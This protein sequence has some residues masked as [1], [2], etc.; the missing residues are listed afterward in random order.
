LFSHDKSGIIRPMATDSPQPVPGNPD[1]TPWAPWVAGCVGTLLA[2]GGLALCGWLGAGRWLFAGLF[3][4]ACA[5]LWLGVAK[6]PAALPRGRALVAILAVG[7]AL[8]GLFVW[9]W[10]AD[11]DL[12]RSVV[13]GALQTAGGNPYLLAPADPRTAALLPVGLGP[14]LANVNHKDLTAVYPPLSE[15]AFRLVAT[16]SPTRHAFKLAAATT[17][18]GACLALA[19]LVIRLGLPVQALALYAANPLVVT[20]T[21]G[22][23]HCDALAALFL[24]LAMLLFTGRRDRTGFVC[25]GAAGMAK[26]LAFGLAPFLCRPGRN[27]IALFTLLPLVLFAPFAG[28]GGHVFDSL[29]TMTAHMAFGA[30]LGVVLRPVCG[31]ATPLVA[32]GLVL[33]A[34]AGIWLTVQDPWRGALAAG[35]VILAGLPVLYPWY[36]LLIIPLLVV[37]PQPAWLWL[38]AGQGLVASPT[39]LRSTDLGGEPF[40]ILLVWLVFGLLLVWGWRRPSGLL[41]ARRFEPVQTLSV[42][43]PTRDEADRLGRLLASLAPA[44]KRGEI[45]DVVVADGGSRDATV[46]V[47]LAHGATVVTTGPSRGGQIAAGVVR[48]RGEA[49]LVLHADAVCAPDVPARVLA[50]LARYP[51]VTGGAVGMRF[52]AGGRRLGLVARLNAWR[53]AMTG[54]SFGDQGQFFRRKALDAVGGFPAMALMEDVELGLRLREA[55]ETVLLGGGLIVSG[56]RWRKRGLKRNTLGVLTLFGRYLLERR[57]GWTDVTGVRYYRAYYGRPPHQTAR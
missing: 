13:E 39:W 28:A 24:C 7:L 41:T 51:A 56:R 1:R 6:F 11:S 35:T 49:V 26:Y 20:M 25:L 32:G 14:I 27:R 4:A 54:L 50:C 55:G 18:F 53:A 23:G 3:L 8:R 43:I 47:A 29:G 40:L 30:P 31:P 37:R 21:A 16:V 34:L 38:C 19:G 45:A 10:P 42:V 57:L 15:L 5:G 52:A 46:A 36:F 12:N 9:A 44:R 2:F 17:D 22:E 33:A 48:A